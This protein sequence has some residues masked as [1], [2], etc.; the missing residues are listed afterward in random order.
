MK[1]Q[2]TPEPFRVVLEQDQRTNRFDLINS[3][4]CAHGGC[5]S[6]CVYTR[7]PCLREQQN[8]CSYCTEIAVTARIRLPSYTSHRKA[9]TTNRMW[10]AKGL[11]Y[12]DGTS[13][14]TTRRHREKLVFVR[15]I[16]RQRLVQE[17]MND[18]INLLQY[19]QRRIRIAEGRTTDGKEPGLALLACCNAHVTQG[20]KFTRPN[21]EQS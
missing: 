16:R 10:D 4:P 12:N 5:H 21:R 6:I 9:T 14:P 8:R 2:R 3:P 17:C 13:G 1:P 11:K 7:G 18:T 19:R 20:N 15:A